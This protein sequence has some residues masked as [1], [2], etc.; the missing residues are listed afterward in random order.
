MKRF[1]VKIVL[2]AIL[3][4]GLAWGLDYV[5]SKGQSQIG[6]YPQQTWTEIGAEILDCDGV[7]MGTSRGLEH[8]N[9]QIIDSITGYRFYNLGMGGYP[10]N[11]ELMKYRYYCR[12]NPIPKY[13]IYDVDYIV[14]NICNSVVHDHQSEQYLPLIYDKQM[15]T[16]LRNIGYSFFDVYFPLVRWWGYQ[17]QIKQSIWEYLGLKHYCFYPSY[18]GH[19]PDPDPYDPKR[20]HFTDSVPGLLN[21]QAMCLFESSMQQWVEDSIQVILINSPKYSPLL[22]MNQYPNLDVYYFDSIA[23]MY[24]VPFI[25]YCDSSFWMCTDSTLFNAGVHLTPQGTKIFSNQLAHDLDSLG[26]IK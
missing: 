25:N 17:T 9:P 1:I 12:H 19:M 5:I 3:L 21:D 20:L 22:A 13:I 18:Q 15:R 11:V 23:T 7:I 8:Y 6:G 24:H 14:M 16:E 2:F 10:L 26:Y 4:Y